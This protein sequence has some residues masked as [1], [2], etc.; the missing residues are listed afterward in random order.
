MTKQEVLQ[1]IQWRETE[2]TGQQSIGKFQD[3]FSDFS[4]LL[5]RESKTGAARS[6]V[7]MTDPNDPKKTFTVVCSLPMTP[8]VRANK[9]GLDE[10]A[11][12]PVFHNEKGFF[13]GMPAQG[14]VEIRKIT[15][16][17]FKPVAVSHADIIG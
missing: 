6:T 7:L 13:V 2:F 9:I 11:G 1:K 8:L 14:W 3:L 10:I 12:F 15:V 4:A 17:E 16:K 5:V